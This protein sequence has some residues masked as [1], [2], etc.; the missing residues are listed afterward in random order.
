M[1]KIYV[2][3]TFLATLLP[4]S[5]IAQR[6]EQLEKAVRQY[7]HLRTEIPKVG[8]KLVASEACELLFVEIVRNGSKE[9]Q[10]TA[11]Y[12]L[13]LSRHI[14]AESHYQLD[15]KPKAEKM[16]RVLEPEFDRLG[17]A[18]FPLRYTFEG[19]NFIIK[20]TD[21]VIT[22]QLFYGEMAEMHYNHSEY[23]KLRVSAE[24]AIALGVELNPTLCFVLYEYMY[25]KA[26]NDA[27][28]VRSAREAIRTATYYDETERDDFKQSFYTLIGIEEMAE[29][30][31]TTAK[32]PV[33]WDPSGTESISIGQ[34]LQKVEEMDSLACV[35]YSQGIDKGAMPDN[36]LR[37][38]I[39]DLYA[40]NG[41]QKQGLKLCNKIM[42]IT[43]ASDCDQLERLPDY[44]K[45]FGDTP[46]SQAIALSAQ[47]CRADAQKKAEEEAKKQARAQRRANRNKGYL[48]FY[49]L[50]MVQRPQYID[51][52]AVLQLPV[53]NSSMLEFSYMQAR[54]DQDYLLSERFSKEENL[55][56]FDNPHWDGF[57]AHFG[58]KKLDSKSYDKSKKAI[59]FLLTYNQRNYQAQYSDVLLKDV[60]LPVAYNVAFNPK[61][62]SYGLMFNFSRM[63]IG[64]M[65]VEMYYGLG[66]V[67][68]IFDLNNSNYPTADYDYSNQFLNI[69]KEAYWSAQFRLGLT[70]GFGL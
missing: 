34:D 18:S 48:G 16:F 58:Y 61:Q 27:E 53:G 54:N 46:K 38:T 69:R 42:A 17:E 50:R 11:N 40:E 28:R 67:Y 65:G 56:D 21:F 10:Q 37:W 22:R 43:P 33:N 23:E 5:G 44:L 1:K 57:Y 19:K 52:G 6:A 66:P 32:A 26:P 68:S 20:Y 55:N 3:I 39:L 59:G 70:V 41:F 15:N 13:Q 4:F 30:L 51:L 2:F 8:D 25:K 31:L 9:E 14:Q 64:K 12:F 45:K 7:N 35:F 24:K 62:T 63:S 36:S 47:K 60:P 29:S 49:V